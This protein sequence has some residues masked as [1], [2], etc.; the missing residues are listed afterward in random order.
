MVL[1]ALESDHILK[2]CK[3]EQWLFQFAQERLQDDCGHMNRLLAV[4]VEVDRLAAIE[5]L[6][7]V[8]H[9]FHVRRSTKQALRLERMLARQVIDAMAGDARNWIA[10]VVLLNEHERDAELLRVKS[11]MP[12]GWD[13][14]NEWSQLD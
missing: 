12:S 13:W 4:V 6:L 7:H 14:A 2:Q 8:F 9:C 5:Q 1:M 11:P 3:G 10:I